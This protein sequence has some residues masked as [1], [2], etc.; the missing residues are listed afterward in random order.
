MDTSVPA[1]Q[2]FV[3]P[4]PC[5]TLVCLHSPP[6]SICLLQLI[7]LLLA[8][9]DPSVLLS[10]CVGV[11]ARECTKPCTLLNGPF[12]R[13][14]S[15]WAELCLCRAQQRLLGF[16][17]VGR[18]SHASIEDA[19]RI[20]TAALCASLELLAEVCIGAVREQGTRL[21]LLG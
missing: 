13:K 2:S 7:C 10:A 1:G 5:G 20:R 4:L 18:Q 12:E 11:V 6:C 3:V 16:A 8:D 21:S 15:G 19:A 14:G 17:C 9:M